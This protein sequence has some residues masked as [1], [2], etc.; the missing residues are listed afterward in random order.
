M[1]RKWTTSG[2]PVPLN[3]REIALLS[4]TSE[5]RNPKP[6]FDFSGVDTVLEAGNYR[7]QDMQTGTLIRKSHDGQLH[8]FVWAVPHEATNPITSRSSLHLTEKKSSSIRSTYPGATKAA[9]CFRAIGR[10]C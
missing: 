1:L 6:D 2:A 4:P 3:H 7:I 8:Q 10:R 5:P 9:S